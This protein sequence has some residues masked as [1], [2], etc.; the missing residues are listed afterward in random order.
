[1]LIA[2]LIVHNDICIYNVPLNSKCKEFLRK[3]LETAGD[4]KS[5]KSR[6]RL[7]VEDQDCEIQPDLGETLKYR[8][9]TS[10]GRMVRIRKIVRF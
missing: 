8:K 4:S 5:E 9:F 7:K 10:A 2:V 1:M 6:I 3:I